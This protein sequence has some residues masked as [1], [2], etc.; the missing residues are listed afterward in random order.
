VLG[1][2][3][4]HSRVEQPTETAS[5]RKDGMRRPPHMQIKFGV[6]LPGEASALSL[7]PRAGRYPFLKVAPERS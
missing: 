1:Q 2:P 6:P 5:M 7:L 4:T 3:P